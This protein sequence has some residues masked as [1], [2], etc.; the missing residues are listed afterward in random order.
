[1]GKRVPIV[2]TDKGK[3]YVMGSLEVSDDGNDVDM[4]IYDQGQP[5][6]EAPESGE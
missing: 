4:I 6:E 2:V 1:M 5:V 3:D